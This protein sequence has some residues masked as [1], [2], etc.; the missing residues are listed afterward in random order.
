MSCVL[1]W[2]RVSLVIRGAEREE[3]E[4]S[5]SKSSTHIV[6]YGERDRGLE[7]RSLGVWGRVEGPNV[8]SKLLL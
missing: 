1:F 6:H 8:C 2:C 7:V 4:E 3:E 5:Q